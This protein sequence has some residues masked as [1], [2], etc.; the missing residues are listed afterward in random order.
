MSEDRIKAVFILENIDRIVCYP[1][2]RT[3]LDVLING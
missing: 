2:E 3:L 1:S